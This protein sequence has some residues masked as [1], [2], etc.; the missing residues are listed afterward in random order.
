MREKLKA[1]R[2]RIINRFHITCDWIEDHP[3]ATLVL[4]VWSLMVAVWVF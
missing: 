3:G 2:D 4:W 1:I